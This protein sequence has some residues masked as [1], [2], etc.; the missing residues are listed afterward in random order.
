M[1][2]PYFVP[3]VLLAASLSPAVLGEEK[4]QGDDLLLELLSSWFSPV[5]QP[6]TTQ[7]GLLLAPAEGKQAAPIEDKQTPVS[8]SSEPIPSSIGEAV[9][10]AESWEDSIETS[11]SSTSRRPDD[12]QGGA[13]P[14]SADVATLPCP[15]AP[16]HANDTIG[17]LVCVAATGGRT[18]V[19]D[20]A[21]SAQGT[22]TP[23]GECDCNG[24]A[25]WQWPDCK[26]TA[27]QHMA[28]LNVVHM[29]SWTLVYTA[30]AVWYIVK[31]AGLWAVRSTP[32]QQAVLASA[33]GMVLLGIAGAL[34]DPSCAGSSGW[35]L[36]LAARCDGPADDCTKACVSV[37][38]TLYELKTCA[39]LWAASA[40]AL[41]WHDMHDNI[42]R[43]CKRERVQ[44]RAY[45]S[46][47]LVALLSFCIVG[48]GLQL[49]GKHRI[50]GGQSRLHA[51][52]ETMRE[53]YLLL[54]PM[55]VV[56][57]LVW[58]L[59]RSQLVLER[60]IDVDRLLRSDSRT[61]NGAA[62]S[63]STVVLEDVLRQLKRWLA[64]AAVL[65]LVDFICV[66][67]ERLELVVRRMLLHWMLEWNVRPMI[68]LLVMACLLNGCMLRATK[69]PPA[70]NSAVSRQSS[71]AAQAGVHWSTGDPSSQLLQGDN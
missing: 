17:G 14:T 43:L 15:C 47:L 70:E 26:E 25:L 40:L 69:K 48:M 37:M 57:A 12:A 38:A 10:A 19:D 65:C 39:L 32:L 42:T 3:C 66:G 8:D 6:N 5:A 4:L 27:A 71:W 24:R 11:A 58:A 46:T 44:R 34:L 30:F 2:G 13:D 55:L 23:T 68:E 61:K 52:F 51:R 45:S 53:S 28:E 59:S 31:F 67:C 33:F 1:R 35:S 60:H 49:I 7:R 20:D 36:S 16:E 41:F 62:E 22:C 21:C 56:A 64:P 18:V 9:S 50:L 54:T 63:V 29:V